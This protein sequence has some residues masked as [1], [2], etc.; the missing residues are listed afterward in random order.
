MGKK[1]VKELG[2][3]RFPCSISIQVMFGIIALFFSLCAA[4]AY[5]HTL[6]FPGTPPPGPSVRITLEVACTGSLC[7][8]NAGTWARSSVPADYARDELLLDTTQD[9]VGVTF[10]DLTGPTKRSL[11]AFARMSNSTN[12]SSSSGDC[13]LSIEDSYYD[14]GFPGSDMSLSGGG[15]ASVG[16]CGS[17][18]CRIN[19]DESV[20]FTT[21]TGQSLEFLSTVPNSVTGDMCALL[22]CDGMVCDVEC[23]TPLFSSG[24]TRDAPSFESRS[25]G[26]LMSVGVS[27]SPLLAP[28][29]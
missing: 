14:S 27:L 12:S 16:T 22:N 26:L 18:P 28:T 3:S 17:F 5:Q 8:V 29:E 1:T 11:G 7:C 15:C 20:G 6:S 4:S 2:A 24:S 10:D 21:Q 19:F 9:C 23:S 13:T 25:A